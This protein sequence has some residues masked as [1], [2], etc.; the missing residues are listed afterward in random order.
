MSI[1]SVF[2]DLQQQIGETMVYLLYT[3]GKPFELVDFQWIKK[4]I[5]TEINIVEEIRFKLHQTFLYFMT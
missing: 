3:N 1:L 4:K 2:V 5:W